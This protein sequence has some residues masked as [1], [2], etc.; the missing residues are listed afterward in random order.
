MSTYLH[1][2]NTWTKRAANNM[3]L[4][5]EVQLC[6]KR[7]RA[8]DT[9][10]KTAIAHQPSVHTNNGNTLCTIIIAQIQQLMQGQF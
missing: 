4:F 5:K 7:K 1:T 9:A 10:R 6:D 8:I 2:W 3:K